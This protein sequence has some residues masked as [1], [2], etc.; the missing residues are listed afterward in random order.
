MTIK[1]MHFL[2]ALVIALPNVTLAQ[3]QSGTRSADGEYC[4][5]LARKYTSLLPA[6][7]APVAGNALIASD[8]DSNPSR[9]IVTLE[10]K[11]QASHFDLPPRQEFAAGQ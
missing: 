1:P 10:A 4:K 7:S 5:A 9:T 2:V 6:I 11:M 8:C 3:T